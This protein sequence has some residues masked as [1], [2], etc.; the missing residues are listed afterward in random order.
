M[1]DCQTA[2]LP[3]RDSTKFI[4]LRGEC[5]LVGY[6]MFQGLW[7]RVSFL[8][9][10]TFQSFLERRPNLFIPFF[11]AYHSGSAPRPTTLELSSGWPVASDSCQFE[12]R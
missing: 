4:F 1:G 10:V 7:L 9:A 5:L 8:R 2:S 3:L 11:L 6:A 12:T